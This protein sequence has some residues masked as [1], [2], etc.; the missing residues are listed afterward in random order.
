M[1]GLRSKDKLRSYIRIE[2]VIL[3]EEDIVNTPPTI[4][5]LKRYFARNLGLTEYLHN[6]LH[7]FKYLSLDHSVKRYATR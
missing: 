6:S 5:D 3:F 1:R 4:E 2:L 7:P